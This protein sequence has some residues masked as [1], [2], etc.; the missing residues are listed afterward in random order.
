MKLTDFRP[1][2]KGTQRG[3]CAIELSISLTIRDITI[4]ESDGKAW[5]GL[6]GK[7]F[8]D[9]RIDELAALVADRVAALAVDQWRDKRLRDA[10]SDRVV[11]LVRDQHPDAFGDGGEP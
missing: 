2:R 4:C 6:P 11:Q 8:E 9:G 1:M 5:A 10:F 7:P 3:F